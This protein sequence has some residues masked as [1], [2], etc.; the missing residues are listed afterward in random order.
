MILNSA[1]F[2]AKRKLLSCKD[3]ESGI[4][5]GILINDLYL[6]SLGIGVVS[7]WHTT[8]RDPL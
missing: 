1:I 7:L 8:E 4:F 5:E 2:D 3:P 6:G